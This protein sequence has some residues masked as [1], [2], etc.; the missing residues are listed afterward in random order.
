MGIS[1]PKDLNP[2]LIMHY[3]NNAVNIS[4]V[5]IYPML[6]RGELLTQNIS[7]A[8]KDDRE[9]AKSKSF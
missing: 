7:P 6:K 1:K 9:S 3:E 2:K 8:F 5:E 4:Y